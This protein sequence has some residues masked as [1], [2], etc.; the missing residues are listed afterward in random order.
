MY[1]YNSIYPYNV[2][3]QNQ[4]RYQKK[5]SENTHSPQNSA[6]PQI[7]D[8]KENQ[9]QN[10]FP[11]GTKVAIDY[12]KGQINISQVLADFRSTIIAINAP[13]DV[14]DEVSQYLNLVEK[15]SLKENKTVVL[16]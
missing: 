2:N 4:N 14:A 6:N 3:Y 5:E 7:S 10:T 9:T 12:T 13:D 1:N 16:E 11:N 15:E 8:N